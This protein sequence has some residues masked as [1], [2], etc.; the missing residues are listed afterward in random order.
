MNYP[1][2]KLVAELV[3]AAGPAPATLG[4]QPSVLLLSPNLRKCG[5]THRCGA[6]TN[7]ILNGGTTSVSSGIAEALSDF[8]TQRIFRWIA[9]PSRR[10]GQLATT[11][12]TVACP[13]GTAP[14]SNGFGVRRLACRPRAYDWV[15]ETDSNRRPFGYE[16]NE[17][18]LLHPA[19]KWLARAVS[20]RRRS[21]IS[22]LLCF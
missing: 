22:R 4:L 18:P 10:A 14:A 13:A 8:P 6:P 19:T 5:G 11:N 9:A 16:P 1:G 17:L 3:E 20:R 15:Q 2:T 7:R 21:V 12:Q